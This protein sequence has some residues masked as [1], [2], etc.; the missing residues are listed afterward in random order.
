[1]PRGALRLMRERPGL[2]TGR[3]KTLDRGKHVVTL[4][5]LTEGDAAYAHMHP[6]IEMRSVHYVNDIRV[7]AAQENLVAIM[8]ALAIDLTG[9]VASEHLG[10]TPYAGPGGQPEIAIGSVLARG[11]RSI[12]V[13]PSTARG[14]AASRIVPQ[15]EVGSV[16]T[17]TRAFV[18]YVVT[19]YGIARLMG[20]SAR[21]RAQEL[22]AV[23]H[24]DHRAELN[25][26]ARRLFW[27]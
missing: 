12:M 21:Q 25:A 27:P 23:A 24:P 14:G 15:L 18:D 9:Q 16:V 13:L 5:A 20:K 1:M 2:F 8:N 17:V 6:Q 22:I 19:E 11:G 10:A 3:R 7:I 26:A 4:L